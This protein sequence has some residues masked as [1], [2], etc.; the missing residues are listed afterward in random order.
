MTSAPYE[1]DPYAMGNP[2]PNYGYGD[3]LDHRL[4][5]NTPV[6]VGGRYS[7]RWLTFYPGNLREIKDGTMR[8]NLFEV[9]AVNEGHVGLKQF[10]TY[11][12]VSKDEAPTL[13]FSTRQFHNLFLNRTLIAIPLPAS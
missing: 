11:A 7:H 6:M 1:S 2:F 13:W 5:D 12:G 8:P 9:V 3:T 10:A 4:P